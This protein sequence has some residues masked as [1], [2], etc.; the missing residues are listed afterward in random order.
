MQPTGRSRW[1]LAG[2]LALWLD[3]AAAPSG[4]L[5]DT[6]LTACFD[7]THTAV[8][9]VTAGVGSDSGVNPRQDARFGRD[10]IT[11]LTK[12]GGGV[13]GFDFTALD[14]SG[15]PTTT[16]GGTHACV[17]DNVTN[18][19]WSTE[20]ISNKTWLVAMD[21]SGG[22]LIDG[23]NTSSRCG[24]GSDWRV[25]T[26][27]ELLSIIHRGADDPAVDAAYFPNTASDWYWSS[28]PDGTHPGYAWI[29]D[30]KHGVAN[31]EF[32]EFITNLPRVRLVRSAP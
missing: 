6:G 21:T 20:T 3:A 29:V 19:V 26:R 18:L 23:Y 27:R 11:G 2:L 12:V 7:A 1:L 17:K 22:S 28:D 4:L 10:A 25:P 16:V 30:F 15:N 24:F 31:R 32:D 14:L 8:A 9:C 13:A 5:N